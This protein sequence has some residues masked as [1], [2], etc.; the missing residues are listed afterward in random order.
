MRK[1]VI[2]GVLILFLL[3]CPSFSQQPIPAPLLQIFPGSQWA[4]YKGIRVIYSF[5][6]LVARV[7]TVS[8][9]DV[10]KIA[11]IVDLMAIN[12]GIEIKIVAGWVK[13]GSSEEQGFVKIHKGK[14]PA[15]ENWFCTKMKKQGEQLIWELEP[16]NQGNPLLVFYFL[17]GNDEETPPTVAKIIDIKKFVKE[18]FH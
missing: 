6:N 12:K 11:G 7:V 3:T 13:Q 4:L 2:F 16:D 14:I 18:E 9:V 17:S 1:T 10:N 5:D 8:L 15:E